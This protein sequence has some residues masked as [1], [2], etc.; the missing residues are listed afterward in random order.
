MKI[1]YI[2]LLILFSLLC[3]EAKAQNQS[4]MTIGK[5]DLYTLIMLHPSMI[6]FNPEL[7]AFTIIR[8][9]KA[10]EKAKAEEKRKK[11]E[12]AKLE[13]KQRRLREKISEED[14][15]YLAKVETLNEAFLKETS[16][17]DIATATLYMLKEVHRR[18]MEKAE[19]EYISS[20]SA[21]QGELL[22]M[23][24]KIKK[25][26]EFGFNKGYT[27]PEETE[28]R[29]NAI[30][31]E[32]NIYIRRIAD[33]KGIQIVLNSG[34]KRLMKQTTKESS[35]L[36]S[37]DYSFGALIKISMQNAVTDDEPAIK[38]YYKNISNRVENWLNE[39]GYVLNRLNNRLLNSDILVG[40]KDLT[41]EV[42]SSIYKTY[43]I[44]SNISNAII[45]SIMDK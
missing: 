30:I 29:F 11:E 25:L 24:E 41:P 9:Q 31:S 40:G 3:I 7:Q 26:S 10:D 1:K 27:T 16:N 28:E 43:K 15:F 44:E 19:S 38:G 4:N 20:I 42:L 13:A 18:K 2:L 17:P 45:Q 39:G 22:M 14:N 33:Q 36:F 34:Y 32:V 23:E 37:N 6:D 5:A 12:V 35:D 8:D 21:L